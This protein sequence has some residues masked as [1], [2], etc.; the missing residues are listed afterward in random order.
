[1]NL[2][3]V[4]TAVDPLVLKHLGPFACQEASQAAGERVGRGARGGPAGPGAARA[5]P[6]PGSGRP[7]TAA[8]PS[9]VELQQ[10]GGV[11][12]E[13]PSPGL[14]GHALVP[15]ERLQLVGEVGQ[16]GMRVLATP[17]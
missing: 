8:R 2:N 12:P 4:A 11:V 6:G 3:P 1:M 16:L 10:P 9:T 17:Q 13:H 7:S 15:E 5:E 14:F